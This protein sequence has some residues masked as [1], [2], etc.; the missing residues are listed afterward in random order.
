MTWIATGSSRSRSSTRLASVGNISERS[1]PSS[2]MSSRRGAGLEERR[3]GPHRLAE[4]LALALAVRVAELE[5]LLPR[6]GLGDHRE[7]GVRDVVADLAAQRDL[8]AAVDLHVLDDVLVLLGQVLG[9][10]L[11]QARRDGCPHRTAETGCRPDAK[12]APWNTPYPL[13]RII[14]SL[15]AQRNILPDQELLHLAA[16][17]ARKVVD[18]VQLLGPLLGG[19]AGPLEV[20]TDLLDASASRDRP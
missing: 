4:E 19:H 20:V 14:F 17:G 11:W 13:A 9:Q 10:R 12:V 18:L 6:A 2:S 5:V 1:R 8:G 15:A 7:G 3:D 16:R